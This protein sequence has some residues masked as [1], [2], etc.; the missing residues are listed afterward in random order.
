MHLPVPLTAKNR[1]GL[2]FSLALSK[3]GCVLSRLLRRPRS[4]EGAL[5]VRVEVTETIGLKSIR[6]HPEQKVT[7]KVRG[8]R[9]THNIVPL[10]TKRFDV[11]ITQSRDLVV[12]FLPIR[13]RR[14]DP[15]LR[16][17]T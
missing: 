16:H 8:R 1:T 6:H 12:D 9:M 2:Q 3:D 10:G 11:E 4:I 7:R 17:G 13:S 15:H 5:T 14:T